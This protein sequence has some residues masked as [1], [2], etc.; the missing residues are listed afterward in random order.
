MERISRGAEAVVFH[1]HGLAFKRRSKK[2]YRHPAI[3]ARLRVRRN[4]REAKILRTLAADGFPVPIV[5]KQDETSIVM[6]ML[7]GKKVRD[8]LDR[9]TA[10]LLCPTIGRLVARLH[11]RDVIHGDLTTS[12]MMLVKKKVYL[13]DFGLSFSSKK[14]EDKA[15]DLHLLRQALVSRH[16][17]IADHAWESICKEYQKGADSA[18]A[19]LVRLRVVE[20]RGR[21]KGK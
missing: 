8:V 17:R 19:T 7:E 21:Y 16:W 18:K 12:N 2:A 15:V 20:G 13:I 1:D 5:V 10:P 11:N 9:R 6:E 4:A 14:I 3:D